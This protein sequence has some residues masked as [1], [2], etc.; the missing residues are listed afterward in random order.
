M[1]E[2][3]KLLL[4]PEKRAA[5]IFFAGKKVILS[6]IGGCRFGEQG[7]T[8]CYSKLAGKINFGLISQRH[9]NKFLHTQ[10]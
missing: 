6:S 1:R 2:E 5:V 10:N 7:S 9:I 3:K 8:F 4:Q